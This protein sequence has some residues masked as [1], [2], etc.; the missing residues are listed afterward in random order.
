MGKLSE[1]VGG[2]GGKDKSKKIKVTNI[3]DELDLPV[4]RSVAYDAFTSSRSS[5]TS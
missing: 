2:G 3:V 1:A 4:P 5:R